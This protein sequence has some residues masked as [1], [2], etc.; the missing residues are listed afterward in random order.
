MRTRFTIFII[1]ILTSCTSRFIPQ[2]DPTRVIL[3]SPPPGEMQSTAAP[4][5]GDN[6]TMAP[7]PTTPAVHNLQN[8]IDKAK[9]DLSQRLS[10]STA[11]INII[12]AKEVTWSNSSLGCPQPGMLYAE[13]LTPGYLIRLNANGQDYEYH[14]GKGSAIFYCE[15]PLP[16][17]EGMPG[18]T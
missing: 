1:L 11:R 13:V 9:E 4:I 10:I 5:Q 15:N 12:E 7:I 2:P 14:A 6:P 8:L 17:V 3:T 18:N 16:P